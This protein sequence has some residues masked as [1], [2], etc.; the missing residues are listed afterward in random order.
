MN[1]DALRKAEIPCEHSCCWAPWMRREDQWGGRTA[2][3]SG[4]CDHA[5]HDAGAV[6]PVHGERKS[7]LVVRRR[8]G[9]VPR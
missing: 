3:S 4:Q 7:D 9:E 1:D 5:C 8:N 2:P 6:C